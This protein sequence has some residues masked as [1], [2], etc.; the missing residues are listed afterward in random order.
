MTTSAAIVLAGGRS[1]RMGRDKAALELDG[2]TFLARVVAA[3]AAVV[4][5]VVV[6]ARP[7]QALPDVGPL[8]EGVALRQAVDAAA[9][10]GPVEGL[11]AGLAACAASIVYVTS[12]DVPHL[13]PAFVARVI[14]ALRAAPEAAAAVPAI[15]GRIHPLAA[16]YRREPTL[17]AARALL[18][19]GSA[20]MTALAE[21]LPHV[22]VPEVDLRAVDP[23]LASLANVNTPADLDALRAATDRPD[24]GV[25]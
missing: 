17:V 9:D 10:R 2:A 8:R 19:A 22:V 13:R 11:R 23:T 12:C 25:R 4:D 6:V 1:T 5:E 24:A 14:A 18:A 20:R 15:E 21:G 16:A 7:G 3:V